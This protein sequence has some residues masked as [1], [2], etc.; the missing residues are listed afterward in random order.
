[1][2]LSSERSDSQSNTTPEII[3][4]GGHLVSDR[5]PF[6]PEQFERFGEL[7][8][9]VY[10]D[11]EA[12][13]DTQSAAG[14]TGTVLVAP[15]YIEGDF[16][17]EQHREANDVLLEIAGEYDHFVGALASI[18]FG[19]VGDGAAEEFERCLDEGFN[20][21][22]IGTINDDG[23]ELVDRD[24]E[25]VLEVAAERGA[26][27]MVHPRTQS[28]LDPDH[29]VLGD[30]YRNNAIFGREVTLMGSLTKVV[31][32]GVLDRY[33]NLDLVYD[34]TGGNVAS[35]LGR[36][37]AHFQTERWPGDHEHVKEWAAFRTQLEERVYIRMSGYHGYQAPLRA[38]LEEFPSSQVLFGTD[39]PLEVRT[40]E[41]LADAVRSVDDLA[42]ETDAR[43]IFSKNA[44]ELLV[45]V[46]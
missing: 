36:L 32:E 31:H 7:V 45:N 8:G 40:A 29:N 1:M 23:V 17:L 37:E 30:E 26:P 35:N 38:T 2:A 10:D 43:K 9:P 4:F 20:G 3:D 14:I 34:H 25:P 42:S 28:S 5:V 21:G 15:P 18:P 22:V 39:F 16:D 33:P 41:E 11:P 44:R 27:L 46:D 13:V 12:Y 19:Y 6:R 24:V